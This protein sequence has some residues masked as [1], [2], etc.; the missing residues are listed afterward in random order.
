MDRTGLR[1]TS[2]DLVLL[3][4]AAGNTP[5]YIIA[6]YLR[7]SVEAIHQKASKENI[8]LVVRVCKRGHQMVNKGTRWRCPV[9]RKLGGY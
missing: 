7:R 1:W 2:S 5:A 8:S 6:K 3:V 4:E 9:C